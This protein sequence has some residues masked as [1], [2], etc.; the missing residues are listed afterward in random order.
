MKPRPS[1]APLLIKAREI[2]HRLNQL[3]IIKGKDCPSCGS[4]MNKMGGC[5]KMDCVG[6]MAKAEGHEA[7]IKECLKKRGG[8]ASL[9]ECAKECGVSPEECKKVI[10]KM[11]DV[12][13]SPHGDVVLM[14][15]LQ[16]ADMA[17]KD[18]YC[19]KNFGKKY[20]ECSEKE[21]AQCDK[22]HGKMAKAQPG[23]KPEKITDI[24]PAFMAESGGQTKSGYF[25]TNG[26]TIETEDAPK[27]KKGKDATN[28]E[29]LSTRM[30]PHAGGG[31]DREDRMG[32]SKKI[33]K[34]SSRAM[35]REMSEQRPV[36]TICGTCG[37]TQ[38]SGCLMPEMMGADLHACPAFKP[39]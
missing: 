28:M 24:N 19:M 35:M 33:E 29:Q 14:D 15:G 36:A 21:K 12:K 8:A 31:V 37:A 10:D 38:R 18:K 1:E 3:E 39:L 5:M 11:N 17:T 30:N 27:K 34:A 16:K 7:K 26:K 13:I 4:K 25:T 20:S 32:E 9:E 22:V 23:Y 2:E 6:S